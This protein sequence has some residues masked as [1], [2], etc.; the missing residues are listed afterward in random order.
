MHRID[1]DYDARTSIRE[2][3]I[4]AY[5]LQKP[6]TT[7]TDIASDLRYSQTVVS[8]ALKKMREREFVRRDDAGQ[9]YLTDEAIA[10]FEGFFNN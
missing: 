6:G 3:A 10:L 7:M 1:K 9:T 5:L 8:R 2:V 4:F